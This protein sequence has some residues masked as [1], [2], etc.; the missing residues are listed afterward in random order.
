MVWQNVHSLIH[1]LAISTIP[2]AEFSRTFGSPTFDKSESSKAICFLPI[3]VELITSSVLPS[4]FGPSKLA[5]SINFSTVLCSAFGK[6][7]A[8]ISGFVFS[9]FILCIILFAV[10]SLTEHVTI[11]LRSDSDESVTNVCPPFTINPE[12]IS[13]SAKLAE[14]PYASTKIF[15]IIYLNK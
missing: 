2:T 9:D 4:E 8:T 15:A 1:P 10:V 6:H 13:E 11:R 5:F 3:N 14:H 12:I 7:P